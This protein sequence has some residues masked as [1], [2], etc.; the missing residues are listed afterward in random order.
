MPESP[1]QK[2]Y[3]YVDETG[4]DTKGGLFLVAL[5]VTDE[6]RDMVASEA[7]RIEERTGKGALKWRKT[8]FKRKVEYIRA[9]LSSP[10]FQDSLFFASYQNT[11]AYLDLTILATA[12]ALLKKAGDSDYKATI[13]V[14]GL[15]ASEAAHFAAALRRLRIGVRKV[16][17]MKD[18][19]NSLLR[20]A[21]AVCG[22]AR[23]YLEGEG[24][25]KEFR[26]AFEKGILR[27]IDTK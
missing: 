13:I 19:S 12:R 15:R 1:K 10:L 14:D 24:Y 16:R 26:W 7:E 4:Q 8:S 6:Q 22:F 23:D 3:C 27:K 17:G 21:D 18:E 20:L 5:V 11:S 2:L 25:T 9:V